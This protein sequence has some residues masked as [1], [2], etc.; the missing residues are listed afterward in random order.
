MN[1]D[2]H[3]MTVIFTIKLGKVQKLTYNQGRDQYLS[4]KWG[5]VSLWLSKKPDWCVTTVISEAISAHMREPNS[6]IS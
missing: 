6:S 2:P 3:R 4:A 5:Y 1:L